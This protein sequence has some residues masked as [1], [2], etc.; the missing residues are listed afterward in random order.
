M[1]TF[2][3]PF[4]LDDFPEDNLLKKLNV[5]ETTIAFSNPA[6]AFN[7][8]DILQINSVVLQILV[9]IDTPFDGNPTLT[10]GDTL[11]A[12]KWMDIMGIDLTER[13]VYL[14]FCVETLSA[15]TQARSYWNPGGCTTG[16]MKVYMLISDP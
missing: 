11:V 15:I 10:I 14:G 4:T 6:G 12:D 16:S 5:A 9:R 1:P 8:G 13:G 2:L 7:I 3:G